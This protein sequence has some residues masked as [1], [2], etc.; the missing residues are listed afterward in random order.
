VLD[1]AAT[2]LRNTFAFTYYNRHALDFILDLMESLSMRRNSFSYR[3]PS[4]YTGGGFYSNE[5]GSN[6]GLTIMQ[7]SAMLTWGIFPVSTKWH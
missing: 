1:R 6:L 2:T 4:P 3:H 5:N 7:L